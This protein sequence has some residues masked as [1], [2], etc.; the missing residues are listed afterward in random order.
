MKNISAL[1]VVV[2]FALASCGRGRTDALLDK[3]ET[4]L[5]Y[6]PDSALVLL[7]QSDARH[8]NAEQRASWCLLNVWAGY[9]AY[10][11]DLSLAQLD[12]AS[13]Y[14]LGRH[15][16]LR[17]AQT[18]YVRAVVREELRDGDNLEW[19]DDLMRGC[20][21]VDKTD[22]Y[23]L[24]AQLWQ[25]Y[26]VEMSNRRWH[27]SAAEAFSKSYEAAEKAGLLTQKVVALIN[28]SHAQLLLGDIDT[29]YTLAI[30]TSVKACRLS[31]EGD[32]PDLYSRSLN[33]LSSCYSRAGM[34]KEALETA[35]QST[36][37]Q[38]E[39][40]ASGRRRD[41]VRYVA[42]ADAWRKFGDADSALFYAFKDYDN[43]NPI[44]RKAALQMIYSTY[45]DILGDEAN[46][47]KY[48][49]EYQ[50]LFSEYDKQQS[51]SKVIGQQ[52]AF[53][54]ELAEKSESNLVLTG[55]L[56]LLLVLVLAALLVLFFKRQASLRNAVLEQRNNDLELKAEQADREAR[57]AE[58][59][60][61]RVT[62]VLI[63]NDPF[64]ESL[65]KE[66]RYLSDDDWKH[67]EELIDKVYDGWCS[68]L[69]EQGLSAGGIR[70]AC[71]MKLRF[72]NQQCSVMLGISPASVTKA[73]QR[74]KGRLS[75]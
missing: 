62:A 30:E 54:Q 52:I 26:G 45:R 18:Y 29:S 37:I 25:R 11:N 70:T 24:A 58:E 46:A 47:L 56:A 19:V 27:E 35:Q 16:H 36:A 1:F 72:T 17:K 64:V 3:A 4:L 73:K 65:R 2:L 20:A 7:S 68:S 28:L 61:G 6:N 9:N 13:E 63:D 8:G 21:E 49:T 71:L 14:F 31:S 43:P 40:Y 50:S 57:E 32:S 48:L 74:L 69:H 41:R 5:I 39:L 59:E 10:R 60:T 42:L 15:N 67:M 38:E 55:L 12:T 33:S 34:L 44:A 75:M 51:A 22:S 53:E 66:S 23:F